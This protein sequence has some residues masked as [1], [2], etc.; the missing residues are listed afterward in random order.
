MVL[1]NFLYFC[2]SSREHV[3]IWT[4]ISMLGIRNMARPRAERVRSGGRVARSG[5]R[6]CWADV[7]VGTSGGSGEWAAPSSDHVVNSSV[8]LSQH[9]PN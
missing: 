4:F 1:F 2:S 8:K 3:L 7:R 6:A 5:R 9:D